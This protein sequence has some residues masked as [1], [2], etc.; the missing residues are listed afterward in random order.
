MYERIVT[1]LGTEIEEGI[2]IENDDGREKAGIGAS[3][4]SSGIGR[5]K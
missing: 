4:W 3:T 5:G 1:T 2:E